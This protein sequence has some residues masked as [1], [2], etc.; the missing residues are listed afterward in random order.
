MCNR[1]FMIWISASSLTHRMPRILYVCARASL[2]RYSTPMMNDE[3]CWWCM[4]NVRTYAPIMKMQE[5]DRPLQDDVNHAMEI[6]ATRSDTHLIYAKI[7]VGRCCY[8]KDCHVCPDAERI[9][10]HLSRSERSRRAEKLCQKFC[11]GLR[12]TS[13]FTII[14][15]IYRMHMLRIRILPFSF[16]MHLSSTL[17]IVWIDVARQS[18]LWLKYA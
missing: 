17:S 16:S 15:I 5:E 8:R 12:L 2:Q 6:G 14:A 11:K 7:V 13:P 4:Y 1:N 3:W 9:N 10:W 18:K